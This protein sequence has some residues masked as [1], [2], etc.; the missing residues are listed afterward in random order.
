LIER[1][2]T[3]EWLNQ[4]ANHEAVRPW[5]A[6]GTEPLDLSA[7]VSDKRNV[8]LMGEHGGC[9]FVQIGPGIFEVHTQ[10]LP[11]GRGAWTRALSEACALYMFTRTE[12]YEIMTRV[13]DGHVGAKAGALAQG[14]RH[15][16]IREKAYLF[17]GRLSD[18]HICGLRIQDWAARAPGM[19]ELGHW[20][21]E[22]MHQELARLGISDPTHEDDENHN[23][24]AGVT[25][26]MARGGQLP[27][28]VLFYNRWAS[29]ARH[30]R[31]GKIAH[32]ALVSRDPPV[33]RFDLGLMKLV[34]DDIEVMRSC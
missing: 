25:L 27:K 23:R 17:R 6:P 5:I 18:I 30:S 34:G 1:H 13:P 3:A 20:L 8:L 33:I 11:S 7:Q 21:H 2:T 19:V 32:I 28:A 26:E 31:G 9:L 12:A 16:F 24:Y 10:V 14:F 15:E 29:L 22:R 4:V